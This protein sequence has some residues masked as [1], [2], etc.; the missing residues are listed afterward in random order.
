[1]KRGSKLISLILLL[2]L[3]V[4]GCLTPRIIPFERYNP[5]SSML[6]EAYADSLTYKENLKL[7]YE[8]FNKKLIK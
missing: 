6:K 1:M 2:G 8:S 5:K 7:F 3:G 4:T